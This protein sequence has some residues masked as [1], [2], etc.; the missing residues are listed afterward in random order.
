MNIGIFGGSFDPPH[1]GHIYVAEQALRECRLDQV[2]FV[3]AFE[4][5]HKIDRNLTPFHHRLR[6]LRKATEVLPNIAVSDLEQDR[7][8]NS[9]TVD[10]LRLLSEEHEDWDLSFLM[11]MDMLLDFRI[12]KP[13][14]RLS[15]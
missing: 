14:K 3:P 4:P 7:P 10:T 12:G 8:G 2:V 11:G 13:R 9:Y 15:G 1:N 6:W 5:P